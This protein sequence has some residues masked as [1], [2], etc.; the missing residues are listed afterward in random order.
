[1][2]R[3]L[4]GPCT[5]WHARDHGRYFFAAGK[6]EAFS[7][8]LIATTHFTAGKRCFRRAKE[9]QDMTNENKAHIQITQLLARLTN[10]MTSDG[11][12]APDQI[13][14]G[15]LLTTFRGQDA[16]FGRE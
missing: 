16:L 15:E 4:E 10:T 7:N 5:R 8:V 9:H 12:F 2:S 14:L 11:A 6:T 13:V 1:M 3:C